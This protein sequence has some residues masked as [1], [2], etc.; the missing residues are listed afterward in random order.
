LSEALQKQLTDQI[1]QT[2]ELRY[3]VEIPNYQANIDEVHSA[4]IK[5]QMTLGKIEK[6]L[7]NALKAKAATDRKVFA[8]RMNFQEQW[9]KAILK[10]AQRPTLG[11][12]A[13][14]KERAA[15]ANLATMGL[16]RDLRK[17]EETQSFA[18]EAVEVI[19]LHYY[20]LDKVRQDLRK[21]LDHESNT[22]YTSS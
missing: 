4:L 16:A 6:F 13:T 20:G 10:V 9:D 8:L 2:I 3:T 14:G 1:A 15:E 7:S 5:A 21:R 22:M 18:A 12:Y 17:E 19:K 11:E